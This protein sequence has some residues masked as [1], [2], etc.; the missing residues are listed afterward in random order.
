MV[1]ALG[2]ELVRRDR[3]ASALDIGADASMPVTT[4]VA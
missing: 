4:V 1:A 3:T 2:S